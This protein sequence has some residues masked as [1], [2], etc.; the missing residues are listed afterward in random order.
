[1]AVINF[2]LSLQKRIEKEFYMAK[3]KKARTSLSSKKRK[4]ERPLIEATHFTKQEIMKRV[5]KLF[6]ENP[7]RVYDYRQVAYEVGLKSTQQKRMLI[8]LLD[9]MAFQNFLVEA[10][11][12]KYQLDGRSGSVVGV[13][14]RRAGG[15]MVV[16]SQECAEEIYITEKYLNKAVAG[17][18]VRIRLFACRKDR[19]QEGQVID[20]LRRGRDMYVGKLDVKENYAFLLVDDKVMTNDI[21]IPIDKIKGGKNG[22]KA[23]VKITDW[24]SSDRNPVGEVKEILGA[25]G[26]NETEM[27]AILLEYG[28]PYNYPSELENLANEIPSEIPEREILRRLDCRG[29]PTFTIDPK[30]AKDFDDA[31]SL[32]KLENGHWEAGVHIADVTYYVR[33]GDEID[34]EAYRR[35]TSVYLVDRTVPMLPEKL[36]NELCSLRPDEDKLCYSVLFEMDDNANVLNYKIKHTVIRSQ[37]RFTYEEA[38]QVIETKE[39]DMKEEILTLDMLAKKLRE[40]RFQLGGIAFDRVEVRFEIDESGKPLSVY[41]KESQD[42]NKLIEEFMLLA[43]KTVSEHIGKKKNTEGK[44][45]TFIYRVHDDPDVEKLN[46][47][48][49]FISKFGYKLNTAGKRKEVTNSI[50]RLLSDVKGKK[51]QNLIE[52]VAIRSMAKALYS[53]EARGHYGLSFDYYTHFTSPIRRY[54][55]VI[56]HRLLDLYADGKKSVNEEEYEEKCKHCSEMEQLAANAE[57]S[58]IK[59]KQV[60]F[61]QDKIGKTYNGVISGIQEWGMYVEL[62]ENKC[63]GMVPIRDLDDDFYTFDEKNYC[64]VGKKYQRTYSL[65]D[66]VV[67]R[68][69]KTNLDK[70]QMDFELI[71]K[72]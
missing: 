7:N 27:H 55:D 12:G 36:S 11:H 15:K 35:A 51:E 5:V 40:R 21:F 52:M 49:R 59:Y 30:D 70:K 64:L 60:E 6:E 23:L 63:E 26:D 8:Q 17:D 54:P 66:E 43:N 37:R 3:N 10:G 44:A 20:I 56:A 33:P 34:K 72:L 32:R 28:L 47:L 45:K 53:T 19:P 31:L 2:F 67:I 58:S 29:V 25:S 65:G 14:E 61:M 13:L 62:N 68:V 57:R 24:S 18:T 71:E 48:S 39:G 41:F 46:D 9:T 22:D 1:M 4:K 38:Q 50:N 69:K 16:C 42:A